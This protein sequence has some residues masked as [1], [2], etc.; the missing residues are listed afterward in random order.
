MQSVRER[1]RCGDID[2]NAICSRARLLIG[3]M[4]LGPVK[5]K[6]AAIPAMLFDR[7]PEPTLHR[8][9]QPLSAMS[10]GSQRSDV[11]EPDLQLKHKQMA[12]LLCVFLRATFYRWLI[13]ARKGASPVPLKQDQT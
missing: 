8:L 2:M 1:H 10:A 4:N 7:R 5:K 9:S 11:V 13:N 3:A 12:D 6:K